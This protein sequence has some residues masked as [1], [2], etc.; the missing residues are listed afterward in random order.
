[1]KIGMVS[2]FPPAK[3]GIATYSN[4]LTEGMKNVVKIGMGDVDYLV[5]LKSGSLRQELK[6][7][8]A[9]EKIDVLHIQYIAAYFSKYTFN[10]NLLQALKQDIPVVT[11]IHEVHYEPRSIRDRILLQLE[12][13]VARR[14]KAVVHTK[15]QAKFLGVKHILHGMEIHP[16]HAKKGKKLLAFGMIG[17]GKGTL[18]AV[19]A[20]RH[21]PDFELTVAGKVVDQRYA[22]QVTEEAKKHKNVRVN[23]GWVSDKEMDRMFR[24]HD[25]AVFPYTWAPYQSGAMHR[26]FAYGLPVVVFPVGAA[27]ELVKEYGMGCITRSLVDGVKNAYAGYAKYQKGI[28]AYR[29]DANWKHIADLHVKFYK[30]LI[31]K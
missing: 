1:M 21:L 27:H 13:Q 10:W 17:P 16:M 9:K 15:K 5:D 31:K 14:S 8:I 23:L 3:D 11:T 22:E 7:I 29:K 18:H 24:E 4:S 26:A 2:G 28:T 30:T 12:K 20:M 6:R 25:I 19:K